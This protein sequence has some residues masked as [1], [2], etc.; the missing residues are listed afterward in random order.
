MFSPPKIRIVLD[1]MIDLAVPFVDVIADESEPLQF[2]KNIDH[3]GQE[4]APPIARR[5]EAEG[6]SASQISGNVGPLPQ[7]PRYMDHVDDSAAMRG[8]RPRGLSRALPFADGSSSNRGQRSNPR[9][10][11]K[12]LRPRGCR[13]ALDKCI[14]QGL[15]E[16]ALIR[17]NALLRVEK[18]PP[19]PNAF[20]PAT[21]AP[22][23]LWRAG[24]IHY[25]LF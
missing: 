9:S 13:R 7:Y 10:L 12:G 15:R 19:S 22:G 16:G 3:S 24:L 11:R 2:P 4:R 17:R 1:E 14:Y 18:R 21:D 8:P 20:C 6:L 23:S 5:V 25:S